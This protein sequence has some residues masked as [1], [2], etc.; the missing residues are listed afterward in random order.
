MK[1]LRNDTREREEL[2]Y[3][4]SLRNW[5]LMNVHITE[6]LFT[7]IFFLHQIMHAAPA[8]DMEHNQWADGVT[9]DE[10]SSV[11]FVSFSVFLCHFHDILMLWCDASYVY[12]SQVSWFDYAKFTSPF[13]FS[14]ELSCQCNLLSIFIYHKNFIQLSMHGK[15][16][17]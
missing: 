4:K 11:N 1:L 13:C 5:C 7:Y 15:L 2:E 10:L 12:V 9:R 3:A 6:N 8:K 17:K 14:L 16:K